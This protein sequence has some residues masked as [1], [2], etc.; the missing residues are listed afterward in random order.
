[1]VDADPLAEFD[2]L[3][4][5]LAEDE[6]EEES[7]ERAPAVLSLLVAASSDELELLLLEGAEVLPEPLEYA[8]SL[9]FLLRAWPLCLPL[10]ACSRPCASPVTFGLSVGPAL[11]PAPALAFVPASVAASAP[12]RVSV[13]NEMAARPQKT[14][15]NNFFIREL[16]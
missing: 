5:P 9:S 1:L 6:G 14:T 4:E 7:D 8:S 10:L 3:P 2:V 11:A 16:L 12:A 13:L 15:G